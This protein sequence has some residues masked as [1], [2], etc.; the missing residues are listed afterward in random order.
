[1]DRQN[2]KLQIDILKLDYDQYEIEMWWVQIDKSVQSLKLQ[3][4]LPTYLRTGVNMSL[5]LPLASPLHNKDLHIK[6]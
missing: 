1:M 4:P 6:D 3:T 2:F 5:T